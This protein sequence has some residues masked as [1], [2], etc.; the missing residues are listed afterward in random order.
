M[1][2][3]KKSQNTIGNRDKRFISEVFDAA[4]QFARKNTSSPSAT[5]IYSQHEKGFR[6]IF[7]VVP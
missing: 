6:S 1:A 4:I 7:L 3:K 5:K 2:K